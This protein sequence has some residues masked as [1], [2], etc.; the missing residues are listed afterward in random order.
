MASR[1]AGICAVSDAALPN[2]V[3]KFVVCPPLVH[4]TTELFAKPVPFTVKFSAAER[5]GADAGFNDVNVGAVT[6]SVM[7]NG[8]L[9][10]EAPFR[11]TLTC[12]FPGSLGGCCPAIE[13]D[14]AE[15]PAPLKFIV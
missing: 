14:A 5:A 8:K 3:V 9:K 7:L 11:D 4:L 1:F 13:K 2:V 15:H 12:Q 10:R 6:T